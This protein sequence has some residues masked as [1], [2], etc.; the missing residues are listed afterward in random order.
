MTLYRDMHDAAI[1]ADFTKNELKICFTLIN[2]T[3][4]YNR[5]AVILTNQ[6]LSRITKV[7]LDR[8]MPALEVVMQ[9]GFFYRIEYP[10]KIYQFK[11]HTSFLSDKKDN[12]YKIPMSENED[13]DEN[14]NQTHVFSNPDSGLPAQL[15]GS[16]PRTEPPRVRI[17]LQASLDEV[18][19]YRIQTSTNMIVEFSVGTG[20]DIDDPAPPIA[21]VLEKPRPA[22]HGRHSFIAPPAYGHDPS[23][24]MKRPPRNIPKLPPKDERVEQ[25]L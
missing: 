2:Q 19:H 17:M 12:F 6:E 10:N 3:L 25:E 11:V 8:L 9:S 22:N 1:E 18:R 21:K 5:T 13:A 4:G 24:P 23:K 20:N 7:R 15:L 16:D 14:G